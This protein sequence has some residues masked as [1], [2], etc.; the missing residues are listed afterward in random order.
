M[1]LAV[2]LA[3][4]S[5]GSAPQPAA[6]APVAH[7]F[8]SADEPRAVRVAQDILA[9]HGNAVDAAVA[10]GLTLAVTLPSR[11]GL[12]GGGACLVRQAYRVN[13]SLFGMRHPTPPP[14][15]ETLEFLPRAPRAGATVGMPGL[16][17]GL[18]ALYARY[19]K[20]H[21]QR[22]V[23]PAENLARFGMPVSRALMR[24][25][26][27]AQAPITGPDGKPLSEGESLTQPDLAN[28]FAALRMHG[29]DG[30]YQGEL[31]AAI[32]AGSGGAIDTAALRHYAPVW[33]KPTGIAFGDDR[34]YFTPGPGGSMASRLWQAV[35]GTEGTSLYTRVV[36]T[37]TGGPDADPKS[38]GR[39]DLAVAEAA[40]RLVPASPAAAA[41]PRPDAATGFVVID[42]EGAVVACSLTMGGRFGAGRAFGRT[43]V[44]E[45]LPVS[46]S[47]S[48]G[49][50]GAAM[51]RVNEN[52][53]K[54]FD[55]F[56]AGADG[57]AEALVETALG[58]LR[59][60]QSLDDALATPRLY[61]AGPGVIRAEK[62]AALPPGQTAEAAAIGAV[63]A[64]ICPDGLPAAE[65]DCTVR[66]DPRGFGVTAAIS[67]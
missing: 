62:G 45:S 42:G 32:A 28:A 33:A 40:A 60:G 27:A 7:G 15:T 63:N 12:G 21:W 26:A 19:G 47:G 20:L 64:V 35:N 56:A 36:R 54:L 66:T 29:A 10:L 30:L 13:T 50:S 46:S 2:C 55:A 37:I 48:D 51:L 53:G 25:I 31:A 3:A 5:G 44:L 43:G 9:E 41:A 67:R 14:P 52:S 23:A 58:V 16:A 1:F 61:A 49:L 8:I 59:G 39:R 18:Y 24:D 38:T 57:G 11:A 6:Q 17:R 22:L 65:P 34:L 4:C